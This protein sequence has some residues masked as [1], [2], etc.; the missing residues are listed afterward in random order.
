MAPVMVILSPWSSSRAMPK[1]VN[2]SSPASETITFS[3]LE[4]AVDHPGL[5]GVLE[6]DAQGM[7][8]QGSHLRGAKADLV[9]QTGA[10]FGRG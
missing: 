10:T 6:R 7:G 3:G 9:G 5:V 2:L 8:R 4:V 1:S